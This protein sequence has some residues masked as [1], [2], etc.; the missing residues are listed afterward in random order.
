MRRIVSDAAMRC[1]DIITMHSILGNVGK[2]AA[3][4]LADGKSDSVAYDTREDAIRHQPYEEYC[5]YVF[6]PPGGMSYEDAQEWLDLNRQ[7]YDAGWHMTDP[8][9]IT[10]VRKEDALAKARQLQN[11]KR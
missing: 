4:R 2:F 8:A 11:A 3:I 6:I 7:L 9:L 5:C 1:S 10:P